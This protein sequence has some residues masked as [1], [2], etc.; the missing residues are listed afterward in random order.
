MEKNNNYGKNKALEHLLYNYNSNNK[1]TKLKYN[2]FEIMIISF[3]KENNETL[4]TLKV[5]RE[6][7][8]ELYIFIDELLSET[9]SEIKGL[10]NQYNMV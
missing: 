8:Q 1:N 10:I 6:F 9:N 2:L 4:T 3:L 7:R 5:N